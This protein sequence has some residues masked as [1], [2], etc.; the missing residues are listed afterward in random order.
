MFNTAFS[1]EKRISESSLTSQK[2]EVLSS[3]V[4]HFTLHQHVYSNQFKG[5]DTNNSRSSLRIYLLPWKLS[6]ARNTLEEFRVVY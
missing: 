3:L 6:T 1:L 2:V 4:G 5:S